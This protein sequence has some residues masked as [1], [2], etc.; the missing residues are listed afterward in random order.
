MTNCTKKITLNFSQSALGPCW[1]KANTTV[2]NNN[3]EQYD[4]LSDILNLLCEWVEKHLDVCQTQDLSSLLMT[5][6]V[7]NH[8]PSNEE[9]LIPVSL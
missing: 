1:R 7:V 9:T 3:S 8:I 5:L 2:V 6:A 4:F